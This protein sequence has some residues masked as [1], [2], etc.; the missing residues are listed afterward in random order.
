[1]GHISGVAET[2]EYPDVRGN[3]GEAKTYRSH[4]ELTLSHGQ[5]V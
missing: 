5:N 3:R 2:I 4:F 1:M